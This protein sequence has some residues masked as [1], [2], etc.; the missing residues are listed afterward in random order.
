VSPTARGIGATGRGAIT[1]NMTLNN[2]IEIHGGK[3]AGREAEEIADEIGDVLVRKVA[4]MF[5]RLA[6]EEGV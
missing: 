6:L 5:E 1:V 2:H 3:G 4:D